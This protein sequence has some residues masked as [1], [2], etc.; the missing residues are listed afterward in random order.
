MKKSI[1]DKVV[2]VFKEYQVDIMKMES[3]PTKIEADKAKREEAL[4]A[5][6][7]ARQEKGAEKEKLLEEQREKERRMKEEAYKQNFAKKE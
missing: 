1:K 4:E 5:T 6:K 2:Q 7:K 3:D